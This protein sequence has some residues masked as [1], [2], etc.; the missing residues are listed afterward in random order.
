L[1]NN[2]FNIAWIIHYLQAVSFLVSIL[3]VGFS[4]A[5]CAF[6]NLKLINFDLMIL[7]ISPG[8][9]NLLMDCSLLPDYAWCKFY[10]YIIV[11]FFGGCGGDDIE[12]VA[13]GHASDAE[14]HWAASAAAR[15]LP[16]RLPATFGA[17]TIN[18]LDTQNTC[19]AAS[20]SHC[21]CRS[22]STQKHMTGIFHEY[23][24]RD[25]ER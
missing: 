12:T 6:E 1:L 21:C 13:I 18:T 17:V 25:S 9:W 8:F 11:M 5:S 16:P 10:V 4:F 19:A 14:P 15:A 24:Q 2:F 22:L 23:D 3:A 20:Q 7:Q